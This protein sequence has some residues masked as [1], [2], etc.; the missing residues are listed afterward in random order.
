[1]KVYLN[2]IIGINSGVYN[3]L[4]A[5]SD[6][7]Q[8]N[9]LKVEIESNYNISGKSFYPNVFIGNLVIKIIKL[10]YS[11]FLYL[12]SNIKIKNCNKR[13]VSLYG[14]YIDL[15]FILLSLPFKK[16]VILD[17]HELVG[18]E[19]KNNLSKKLYNFILGIIRN[20]I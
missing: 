1:M 11:L 14:S 5:F 12:Y 2:D 15:S 16:N 13:I 6:K 20:D 19:I 8:E 10:V 3:Y 7:L 17:L 9:N 4:N 18:N